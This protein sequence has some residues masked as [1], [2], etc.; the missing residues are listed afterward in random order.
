MK[1]M[2]FA[3]CVVA[4]LLST[5]AFADDCDHRAPPPGGVAYG[6][7]YDD[8]FATSKRG[9]GSYQLENR[10]RWVPESCHQV[11]VPGPFQPRLTQC[12]PGH[13]ETVEEWVFVPR[14]DYDHDGDGHHGHRWGHESYPF[15]RR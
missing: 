11:W 14:Y 3:G 10:Q 2:L 7:G 1:T 8:G 15:A 5:A 4:S 13:Y 6:V 9:P 12:T